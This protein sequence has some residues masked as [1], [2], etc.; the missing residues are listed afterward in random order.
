MFT[1]II[2][3]VG[4]ILKK[5]SSEMEISASGEFLDIKKG[6]SVAVNGVCLTVTKILER[7]F[8]VNVS[9]E[10]RRKTNLSEL[11]EGD[12]VNLERALKINDRFNGHIVLG[13]VDCT[14]KVE[15]IIKEGDFSTWWFSFPTEFAKYLVPKGSIAVDGIS[16][17]IVSIE[18]YQFSVAIIPTTFNN[19]TLKYKKVG[20]IVNL[21]ADIIGK[22]V[23][24]LLSSYSSQK[25]VT[26]EFL[27]QHGFI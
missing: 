1:G 13:H 10:T 25:G 21:E 17:T 11:K 27:S 16:L 2:E 24:R 8:L 12:K 22:Y 3:E 5:S 9:P 4:T 14:G 7:S 15:K 6:E 23:E 19:T 18:R 26:M 20:D